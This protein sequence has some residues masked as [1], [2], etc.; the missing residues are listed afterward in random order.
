MNMKS[1]LKIL[2]AILLVTAGAAKAQK[3]WTLDECISYALENNLEIESQALTSASGK[4][5]YEQSKRNRLPYASAGSSYRINYG[6]SIDPNTNV[7]INNNFASNSYALQGGIMLFEGF[8]R[9]NH[10]AYTRFKHLAGIELEKAL[11]TDIAFDVMNSFYN[12]LYYRGLLGIVKEQRELS[13]LNLEKIRKQSQVGISARTDILEIEARLAE[14]ELQ[15]IRTENNLKSSILELK[16]IMNFPVTRELDLQEPDDLEFIAPG[17][18]ADADSIYRLALKHLPAVKARDQQLKSVEKSLAVTRGNFYPSL[19]LFG[20]YYTG[21]YE[22]NTDAAGRPIS[23]KNQM[24]NNASQSVGLSLSIPLFN[25]LNTRSEVKLGKLELEK[26]Q[27]ELAN[28]KNQLYYEIESYCQELSA[29]AAEFTQAQKQTESNLL[30]FEVAQKKKEQGLFNLIDLY[31]SK[32]LLSNAQSQL[33]RTRL[34]YLLKRKTIDF[35]MGKPVFG[36]DLLSD[37]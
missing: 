11:M 32:N 2:I 34:Q 10:T 30:A 17:G 14:E 22:T 27:V 18:F 21:Y 1:S 4:E 37:L 15:V 25:R 3:K 9:G 29:M 13:E 33:L 8:I 19:S 26:E 12:A 24:R 6:K 36:Q 31:T 20:G 5:I 16:R 35:Y 23:F 28:Y 7:I